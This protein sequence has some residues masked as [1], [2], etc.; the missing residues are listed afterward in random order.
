MK[1]FLAEIQQLNAGYDSQAVLEGVNLTIAAGEVVAVLGING[2]GKTTLIKSLLGLI[3]YQCEQFSLLGYQQHGQQRAV[4]IK[5][6]LGVMLQL[7]SV[8]ATL[9]VAEQLSAF[10]YYYANPKALTELLEI[11]DLEAVQHQRCGDLSAGQQQR[12]LL[13]IALC[14]NPRLLFLDEPTVGM[15]IHARHRLWHQI[16]ELRQQQVGMLLTTHYL[17]EAEQLA[18]RVVVLHQGRVIAND[19][20]SSLKSRL[21]YQRIRCRSSL[22][23]QQ[24]WQL[25]GVVDVN[26]ERSL[27]ITSKSA[28]DTLRA[29]LNSD[30]HLQDLDVQMLSLEHIFLHLTGGQA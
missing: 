27:T 17:E 30:P 19:S 16:G 15:D 28:P 5:Q 6:Q 12:L 24:L 26:S 10:R 4:G 29:L 13:A 25:P 11:A 1:P 23:Q 22:S 14:G 3:P 20:V 21:N 8:S 9:T 7:G 2:A 18:D